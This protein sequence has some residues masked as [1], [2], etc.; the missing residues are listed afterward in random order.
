MTTWFVTRHPGAVSW[1]ARQDLTV[2]RVVVH[3]DAS[4]V[5]PGDRVIGTLPVHMAAAI[6]ERGATYWHLAL[7]LPP[8]LRGKELS[9]EEMERAEARI[10]R[11]HVERL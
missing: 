4:A 3:L 6:C 7:S 5:E 11:Y 8:Q 10:E 2:D 1:A 9:V